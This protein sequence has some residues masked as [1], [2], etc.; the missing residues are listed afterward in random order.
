MTDISPEVLAQME[1]EVQ[2]N[3]VG[4]KKAKDF[5]SPE[6]LYTELIASIR[7]YHPSADI[8]GV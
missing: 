2:S 5:T 1:A 7:K 3:S 6:D 8:S 4:I